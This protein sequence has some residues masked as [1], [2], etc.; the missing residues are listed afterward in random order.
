MLATRYAPIGPSRSAWAA[1]SALTGPPAGAA[2]DLDNDCGS[3]AIAITWLVASPPDLRRRP[4]GNRRRVPR[5]LVR[6]GA[7][8]CP[9]LHRD[10]CC[11]I[12]AAMTDIAKR[13][14]AQDIAAL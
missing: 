6:R 10:C 9:S 2:E 14:D 11:E 8:R 12:R 3:S 5:Y 13:L 7:W 1:S 4:V